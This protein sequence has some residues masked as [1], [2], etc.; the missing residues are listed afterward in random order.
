M[1]AKISDETKE[2]GAV[3]VTREADT[4]RLE[5]AGSWTING[6]VPSVP[7]IEPQL[8]SAQNVRRLTFDTNHL[9]DWDS[10]LLTFLLRL[11]ELCTRRHIEVDPIGLPEGVQRLLALAS[12]VP[13]RAGVRREE[14]EESFLTRV[15]R[16][17][18]DTL[19]SVPVFLTFLGESAG[20][21]L[22][23]LRGRARFRQ[24]E[25]FLILQ[26]CG[27]QAL[28]IVSLISFLSGLILAFVGAA[29]LRQFGAEIYVAN[30]VALGM[31][32]EM[33]AMM[34]GIIMA[35]RTGAAFAAQLGTMTV[36]QEID[37]LQ[38]TGL[39]PM[40]FLVMPRMLALMLMVP[41]LT[42]YADFLGML[43]GG[44]VSVAAFDITLIQYYEQT[45]TALTLNDLGVG[46]IKGGTF[47]VLVALAGCFRGMRSG[48]NAAAVGEAATSAVV[49][50]IV[51]IVVADAILT[52]IY[53]VLGI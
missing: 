32:R 35:G 4:L 2:R 20:A 40:E 33:G 50:A 37:A 41:L 28:P 17:A 11:H 15:G 39:S 44:F 27:A 36:N 12:A 24:V 1:A 53:N 29:Q 10:I 16:L 21:F 47:G 31:A 45:R 7:A 22:K 3:A 30:L 6:N 14:S 5:L 52:V 26:Q 49:T 38:T 34:T 46:F 25:F 23:L 51:W 8:Q 42:I 13:E 18:L 48:R 19:A 9:T 43:G